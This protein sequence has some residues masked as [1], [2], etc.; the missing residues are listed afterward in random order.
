MIHRFLILMDPPD[1]TRLRQLVSRAFSPKVA[2]AARPM[3][4]QSADELLDR[5]EP[6]G[7]ADLL[8][9]YAYRLP[10]LVICR[11]LGVPPDDDVR[12]RGWVADMVVGLD[13]GGVISRT[14]LARADAAA[15]ALDGYFRDLISRRRVTPQDDLLS[16]LIGAA[17]G[18]DRLSEDELVAFATLL[19][20][21]GHETTAN[22]IGN[23]LWHLFGNPD[24]LEAFRGADQP[25]RRRAVEELLRYDSPV[26]LVQRITT[27]EITIGATSIPAGRPV[28]GLLGAGNRDPD[29]FDRPGQLDLDRR[30]CHPLSF[31]FGAHHCL[32]AALARTEAE[33]ALGHLVDRFGDL[34][35]QIAPAAMATNHRLPRSAR[36][37]LHVALNRRSR[38]GLAAGPW[39]S[40]CLGR[41]LASNS[42]GETR[43]RPVARSPPATQPYH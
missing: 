11:L 39:P 36:A 30:D 6:T 33:I 27:E 24:Q 20:A 13:V 34:R 14:A 18:D 42:L 1:H 4:E 29:R 3:I 37:S 43:A 9:T 28:I 26:Q 32:G 19:L 8:S 12:F 23:G 31:G 5:L 16:E 35:P 40:A 2:D 22:L 21:A 7:S 25:G 17:D 10:V 41:P 38:A 15:T